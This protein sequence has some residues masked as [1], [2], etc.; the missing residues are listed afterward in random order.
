MSP[1]WKF[2]RSA[3]LLVLVVT[4][5]A[6]VRV[7]CAQTFDLEQNRE[8]VAELAGLWRFHTGDDPAWAQ[9]GY[10]DSS[11]K[12]LRSD[13]SWSVQGYKGYGGMAWYRFQVIVP[14]QHPPLA[15]YVPQFMT[16]YQVYANGR[17]IH[18]F[19][20][21]PPHEKADFALRQLI[22]IPNDVL[23]TG[24]PV[25]IAIRV[26]HWPDW[27][28]FEGGGPLGGEGIVRIGDAA[29]LENFNYLA[30]KES[31]WQNATPGI[32][33]MIEVLAGLAGVALFLLGPGEREYL[34]F[35]I[36]QLLAAVNWGIQLSESLQPTGVISAN[37][38]ESIITLGSNLFLL[39]F[40]FKLLRQ[41]RGWLYWIAI[42]SA[43]LGFVAGIPGLLQWTSVSSWVA[44][45]EVAYLPFYA[46]VT[47]LLI[48]AVRR[49]DTD[50]K[51]LL[52]PF[53]L[54]YALNYVG[55]ILSI[56]LFSGATLPAWLAAVNGG[57]NRLTT[58]P[59]PIGA[60]N[61]ADLL[62]ELGLLGVLLLRFARTR[63]DEQRLASELEAAR[64]VQQVLVPEE[65]PEVAGLAIECVYRPAGEVGGDFFQV[66]GLK[67]KGVLAVIGDV[68]GKGMPAAM[69]VSL[70]VGTLRT[71]AHYTQRPAEILAALNQRMAGR[72]GGG[73]TTC[74]ALRMD[75]DGRCTMANA[76][77]LSP[78]VNGRELA[79]ENG[80]PLGVDPGAAYHDASFVLDEG[81]QLT[82][83]TDG[84]VEARSKTG[85]L[86]GFE[87]TLAITH[88]DAEAIAAAAQAF[89]QNDDITVLTLRRE[90]A[91]KTAEKPGPVLVA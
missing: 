79:V 50:A 73:F 10:N 2:V 75:G 66:I 47:I 26:W 58:W 11:W 5:F 86:F 74:L 23:I 19:G 41:R 55:V 44:V 51:L 57:L 59:F 49:G 40:L 9:P 32:L 87:R 18:Q 63:R 60:Q 38:W 39:A 17:M 78:Y 22:P 90:K 54:D 7:A 29:V 37:V 15:L 84:V 36:A 28:M 77:H 31:F 69:T 67:D 61:V 21:M 45:V 52:F 33:L 83:L 34:W 4:L 43:L 3:A 80:L 24:Q 82:L 20:G 12:L 53:G 91:G 46:C 89:G 56:L 25:T 6:F 13:R 27:A 68:S 76:G 64:A 48:S 71:L 62:F 42:G 72:S 35:G 16:S 8:Q 65:I 88:G 1:Q 85:E 14:A 70:L 81:A 30:F